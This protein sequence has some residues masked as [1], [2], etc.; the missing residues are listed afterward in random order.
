[1]FLSKPLSL[2]LLGLHLTCL[3]VF[4]IQWLQNAHQQTGRRLFLAQRLHPHYI[5]YTMFVSNFVGIAFARTLHYQFYAW[6][7]HSLP[8]LL[9]SSKY[10][11]AVRL[12]LLAGV[13]VA[14]L[15]F[16]ATPWSSCVLQL[17]HLAILL[18]IRPPTEIVMLPEEDGTNKK[19]K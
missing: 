4:A 16:P 5:V 2:L 19:N 15:T 13:E 1:M 9:W 3:T 14:F 18:Q 11:L 8:Y 6:Y 17:C 10:P 7:F 12:V